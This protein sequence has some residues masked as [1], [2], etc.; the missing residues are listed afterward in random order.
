MPKK[1]FNI[2]NSEIVEDNE[3]RQ[4]HIG[5]APGEV[6]NTVILVGDPNR[7]GKVAEL[8]DSVTLTKSNREF[9]TFTG[10]YKGIPITVISTGIG[11]SNVEI[12]V[13]ELSRI[14][15]ELGEI[16]TIIRVGSSGGLQEK[17]K[18]GEL[19]ISTSAVRL[20][21]TSTNFVD[22]SYPAIANYEVITALVSAAE[23]NNFNYHIGIT[24][25]ASGFYG[26]QGRETDKFPVKDS[27][28]PDKLAKW[29]VYNYE[30]ESSTLFT[31]ASLANYRAGTVCAVYANRFSKEFIDSD[32]K[33]KAEKNSIICGLDAAVLI[34]KMDGI[35]K[36]QNKTNWSADLRLSI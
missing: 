22:S 30:M 32:Q 17:I 10:L 29:N 20:E 15:D 27:H 7:A 35:K 33:T 34:R 14:F 11:S 13:I 19:V 21:D 16:P 6:A 5:L 31:L 2:K 3:K 12:V 24:A 9:N 18:I 23:R 36:L 25:T 28:L 26:A 8:F 1:S 4:Y